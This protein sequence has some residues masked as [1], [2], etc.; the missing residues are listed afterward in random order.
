[1]KVK[2]SCS[3]FTECNLSYAM[4]G[5]GMSLTV[6]QKYEMMEHNEYIT[7]TFTQIVNDVKLIGMSDSIL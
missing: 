6:M 7:M 1:M 5:S 3:Q 2:K 4:A